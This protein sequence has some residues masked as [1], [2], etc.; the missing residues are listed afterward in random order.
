M[1]EHDRR[2]VRSWAVTPQTQLVFRVLQDGYHRL[3]YRYTQQTQHGCTS[4]TRTA[5]IAGMDRQHQTP[6][7]WVFRVL[8]WG[9]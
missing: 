4:Y 9:G 8:V 6:I 2:A 3:L 7:D 5:R 1:V